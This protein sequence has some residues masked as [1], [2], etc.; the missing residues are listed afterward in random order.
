MSENQTQNTNENI[1]KSTYSKQNIPQYTP[2]QQLNLG[3]RKEESAKGRS[4]SGG[5]GKSKLAKFITSTLLFFVLIVLIIIGIFALNLDGEVIKVKLNA[6]VVNAKD[7]PVQDAS[8][9]I[10]DTKVLD[11]NV[12]GKFVINNLKPGELDVKITAK[13]YAD[14]EQKLQ[15]QKNFP[16]YTVNATFRL[17]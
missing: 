10:N 15:I 8:V 1:S 2:V 11:T 17:T 4:T 7:E 13:G 12:T 6:S 3:P 9:F 5:K 14:L 16:R